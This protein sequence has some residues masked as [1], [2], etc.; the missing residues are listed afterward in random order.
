L[1]QAGGWKSATI[2]VLSSI[3][4]PIWYYYNIFAKN[5]INKITPMRNTL[6]NQYSAALI[7]FLFVLPFVSLNVIVGNRIEP[8]FSIIRPGIQT[9]SVEYGLLLF[10]LLLLPV[11]AFIAIRPMIQKGADGKRK[12]FLVNGVIAALLLTGFALLVIGLGSEIYRCD[13]L[14]I[15]NCD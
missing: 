15:P 3:I 2:P 13:V 9:S 4:N 5:E 12:F 11:G 14:L 7:G 8:F 6:T 10:V 1:E